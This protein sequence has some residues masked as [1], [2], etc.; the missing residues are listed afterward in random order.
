MINLSVS[1]GMFHCA[2]KSSVIVPILKIGD[3]QSASNYRPINI[4]PL[5]SKVARKLMAVKYLNKSYF[6]LHP[7]QFGFRANYST[8]MANCYFTE[9]VK[10]L[11]V[12][13]V[14]VHSWLPLPSVLSCLFQQLQSGAIST[15]LA[16][17]SCQ[18]STCRSLTSPIYFL[19][20]LVRVVSR[21]FCVLWSC[22]ALGLLTSVSSYPRTR[23]E[24]DFR[25]LSSSTLRW[26]TCARAG[27]FLFQL[28]GPH[29]AAD[30]SCITLETVLSCFCYA[31]LANKRSKFICPM[32][33]SPLFSLRHH[34]IY[35]PE[36]WTQQRRMICA[37][38]WSSRAF[39]WVVIRRRLRLPAARIP[40]SLSSSTGW[41]SGLI[42]CTPA[43][44]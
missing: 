10:S 27:S 35:W 38:P 6:D 20:W 23:R 3:P 5:V 18:C 29:L 26:F 32:Y 28:V 42:S 37:E 16:V 9:K 36:S 11:L 7:I 15:D 2:W 13:R 12:S 30:R 8:E 40:R 24:K 25:S 17:T 33:L 31:H 1:Q 19:L 43:L 4:L 14:R 41:L 34:R 44:Q 21:L 39:F 22:C